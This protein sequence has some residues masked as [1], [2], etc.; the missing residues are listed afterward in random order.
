MMEL[1]A[2][3][4]CCQECPLISN[5]CSGCEATK[6]KPPWVYEAGFDEGCPIYDCA[7]NMKSYTHCG[8]CSK[9]PCE[10][11]S[12]LRD[13]SMSDEAFSKSLSE[14]IAWLKEARQ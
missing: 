8:Q 12:R 13:P 6:G 4:L 5:H 10:I 9:L 11:F 2:C 7:V 1:N 14:R 3:G